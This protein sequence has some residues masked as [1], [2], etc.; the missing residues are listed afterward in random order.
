MLTLIPVYAIKTVV[1]ICF[2]D[3]DVQNPAENMGTAHW[4]RRTRGSN[5]LQRLDSRMYVTGSFLNGGPTYPGETQRS[6]EE[7]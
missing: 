5:N 3:F 7:F 6:C 2:S 1:L 4:V